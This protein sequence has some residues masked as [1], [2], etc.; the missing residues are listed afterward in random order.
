MAARRERGFYYLGVRKGEL[1]V[2]IALRFFFFPR[3]VTDCCLD[4]ETH[5]S[6]PISL[7]HAHN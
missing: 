2:K 3:S 6:R 5:A 1:K 7:A 4:P